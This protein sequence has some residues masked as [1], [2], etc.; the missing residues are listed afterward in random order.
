MLVIA[1]KHGPKFAQVGAVSLW[2]VFGTLDGFILWRGALCDAHV[3]IGP[4]AS[5]L[6]LPIPDELGGARADLRRAEAPLSR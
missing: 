1:G 4:L 3:T 2:H 5:E 6:H